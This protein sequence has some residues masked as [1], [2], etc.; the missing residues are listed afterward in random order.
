MKREIAGNSTSLLTHIKSLTFPFYD[1]LFLAETSHECFASL[2]YSIRQNSTDIR[3]TDKTKS[4]KIA[5]DVYVKDT[6]QISSIYDATTNTP[7]KR[8]MSTLSSS[9]GEY[10]PQSHKKTNSLI[11]STSD[12][13]NHNT[14]NTTSNFASSTSGNTRSTST[15][16]STILTSSN[17]SKRNFSLLSTNL[18]DYDT[19]QVKKY[20]VALF[21]FQMEGLKGIGTIR[22]YDSKSNLIIDQ[23]FHCINADYITYYEIINKSMTCWNRSNV[24]LEIGYRSDTFANPNEMSEQLFKFTQIE[25][26]AITQ[27]TPRSELESRLYRLISELNIYNLCSNQLAE[28]AKILNNKKNLFNVET[29]DK[30]KEYIKQILECTKHTANTDLKAI[31]NQFTKN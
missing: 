6:I 19:Q 11:S 30:L 8:N 27:T 21:A 31:D 13:S 7:R 25:N 29:D 9:L 3:I 15:K 22:V 17:P 2:Y 10:K 20:T 18:R 5:Y 26:I 14:H 24:F 28:A 12:T 1:D 16:S 23:Y 4:I